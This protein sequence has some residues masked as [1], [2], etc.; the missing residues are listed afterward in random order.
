MLLVVSAQQEFLESV[1]LS[2]LSSKK[3][4]LTCSST[5]VHI[6]CI[7]QQYGVQRIDNG[8]GVSANVGAAGGAS[9]A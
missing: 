9:A 7:E 6:S 4:L 5:Q 1:G 3:D 8:R 2:L